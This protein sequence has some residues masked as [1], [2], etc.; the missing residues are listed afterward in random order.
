MRKSVKGISHTDAPVSKLLLIRRSC[1]LFLW[2]EQRRRV[3]E[4]MTR[5]WSCCR[6]RG[7][8]RDRRLPAVPHWSPM[9][10]MN[11]SQWKTI[12]VNAWD[13][14]VPERLLPGIHRVLRRSDKLRQPCR[15]EKQNRPADQCWG[16]RRHF[17]SRVPSLPPAGSHGCTVSQ[18]M[19][20]IRKELRPINHR[21]KSQ[22]GRGGLPIES[23]SKA[24]APAYF[25]VSV[26]FLDMTKRY[27]H[28]LQLQGDFA[29]RA[30]SIPC[31]AILKNWCPVL[32]D[33]LKA[34]PKRPGESQSVARSCQR[35]LGRCL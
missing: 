6:S 20:S 29:V 12:L 5:K 19:R 32:R 35:L 17:S 10:V 4:Q 14:S 3:I 30:Y 28:S 25:N 34:I 7:V 1:G 18:T 11:H 9:L 33:D 22:H 27:E 26:R 24:V 31:W 2:H 23:P 16:R 15:R 8:I 13:E 21:S